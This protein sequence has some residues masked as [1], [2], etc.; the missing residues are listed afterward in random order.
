MEN[1]VRPK[2][3]MEYFKEID[4]P[5]VVGRCWHKLFDILFITVAASI[6]AC[7]EWK[8]IVLWAQK[9]EPWLRKYRELPNGIP[10][11]F[12]FM[13]VLQRLISIRI[14]NV[15]IKL[16]GA[17]SMA[18]RIVMGK[19]LAIPADALPEI[20]DALATEHNARAV[21]WL[22]GIRLVAMKRTCP[23][24]AA[25][26]NVS[27]REVRRWTR[28]FLDGGI[29]AMRPRSSPGAPP[30]LAVEDEE[31]F[32]ERIRQG[33]TP[34]DGCSTWRGPF[35]REMLAREFGAHYR[36][37]SV[38][39]LRHRLGF[40]FGFLPESSPWHSRAFGDGRRGLAYDRR[41]FH[42]GQRDAPDSSTEVP[43]V[44]SFRAAMA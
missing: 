27:D 20:E 14:Y 13:R 11:R 43:G 3:F 2:P 44:Q 21:R 19:T 25:E 1:T 18:R 12:V 10:S 7:D 17:T 42:S 8:M 15:R 36:G 33:P 28:R 6:A 38:Y 37:T 29:E 35:V 24:A 22:L 4:D 16:T 26:L 30:H 9:N 41:T 34:E 39:G 23:Q 32:K 40:S 31:R 5:R